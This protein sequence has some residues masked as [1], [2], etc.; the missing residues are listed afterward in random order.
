MATV[1]DLASLTDPV[2]SHVTGHG[3]APYDNTSWTAEAIADEIVAHN[4]IEFAMVRFDWIGLETSKGVYNTGATGGFDPA[5]DWKYTIKDLLD[6]F[7]GHADAGVNACKVIVLVGDRTFTGGVAGATNIEFA[8]PSTITSGS[9]AFWGLGTNKA[10]RAKILVSGASNAAN[11]GVFTIATGSNPI[12]V[13]E[14]TIVNESPGASVDVRE[15][16]IP[17]YMIDLGYAIPVLS[18]GSAET[19][20]ARHREYYY[21]RLGDCY[22][23][24]ATAFIAEP[25]FGGIAT[26]ETSLGTGFST[27]APDWTHRGYQT[28]LWKQLQRMSKAVPNHAVLFYQNFAGDATP[29][30]TYLAEIVGWMRAYHNIYLCCPNLNSVSGVESRVY[31]R[32]NLYPSIIKQHA[33]V[34]GSE[35]D[36]GSNGGITMQEIYDKANGTSVYSAVWAGNALD[37]GTTNLIDGIPWTTQ[38]SVGDDFQYST[39]AT[40]IIDANPGPFR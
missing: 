15:V 39:D 23:A 19:T 9:S 1:Q 38:Q 25:N 37:Q 31:P 35:Y 22:D 14:A 12:V 29:G 30:D 7:A 21:D 17:E 33:A 34:Q 6:Y 24:I 20:G 5:A 10:G 26:A 36:L 3:I 11:N 32:Y 16:M 18:G 27:A 4:N 40:D 13:Q 2:T 8:A 28:A